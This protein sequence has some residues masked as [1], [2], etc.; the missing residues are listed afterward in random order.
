MNLPDIETLFAYNL[1]ANQRM[2]SALEKLSDEQ[3]TSTM[4]SSF[5]SIRESVLHM[6]AA[7]W[8]WLKRWKGSSP[9]ATVFD[10]GTGAMM[11]SALNNGGVDPEGLST[12]SDLRSFADSIEHE[13][14]EFLRG[15]NEDRLCGRVEYTDMSG[16]AFS[17]PL[18]P[19]MQHVVN[20][21]TYHR[22]QVTTLLRQA[23]AETVSLDM[24]YFFYEEQEN[25]SRKLAIAESA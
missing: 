22:G 3:F 18:A 1:W 20:H 8:I 16:K 25:R 6:L 14:R 5:P 7:E 24:V 19:L 21:G 4:Q 15:L 12:L 10:Q 23:G 13:R 9:R 17:M 11:N 2:F